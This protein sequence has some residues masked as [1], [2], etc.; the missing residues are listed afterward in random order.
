MTWLWRHSQQWQQVN[1]VIG[2]QNLYGK[3]CFGRVLKRFLSAH[4]MQV[5]LLLATFY[6]K[7][8]LQFLSQNCLNGCQIGRFSYI[9]IAILSV[10]LSVCLSVRHVPVL[11]ENRLTY[12]HNFFTTRYPNHSSFIIIKH[13]HEILMASPPAGALN[14]GGYKN[15]THTHTPIR[16]NDTLWGKCIVGKIRA[17]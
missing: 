8:R 15:H 3:L 13:L 4:L 17:S 12:C 11:D 6:L 7:G 16:T 2:L 1:N 10:C 9:D 14:T 5:K